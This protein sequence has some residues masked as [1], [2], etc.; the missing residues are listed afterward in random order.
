MTVASHPIHESG[1]QP[2]L[3][4]AT[5]RTIIIRGRATS[6]VRKGE[7]A[8]LSKSQAAQPDAPRLVIYMCDEIPMRP[9]DFTMRG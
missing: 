1:D 4:I 8:E 5:E 9:A 7:A 3:A 6:F 2:S